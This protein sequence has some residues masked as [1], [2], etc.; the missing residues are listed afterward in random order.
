MASNRAQTKVTLQELKLRRLVEN[1]YRLRDEL[2]RPR[3]MVSLASLKWVRPRLAVT[4]TQ[5][6]QLLPR[7]ARSTG[8]ASPFN[9]A[10]K[11]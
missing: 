5:S 9:A 3:T 6:D 1:N 4:H 11:F 8:T 2:G 7:Y 10:C